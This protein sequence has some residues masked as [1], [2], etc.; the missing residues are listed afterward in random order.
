MEELPSA[1]HHEV[2]HVPFQYRRPWNRAYCLVLVELPALKA[3]SCGDAEVCLPTAK[4]TVL[5]LAA[6]FSRIW[7]ADRDPSSIPVT[8]EVRRRTTGAVPVS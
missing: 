7:R 2:R 4:G 3:T 5:Y 6:T 8:A 1:A